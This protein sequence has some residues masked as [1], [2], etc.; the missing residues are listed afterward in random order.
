MSG[1]TFCSR[2]RIRSLTEKICIGRMSRLPKDKAKRGST[3]TRISSQLSALTMLWELRIAQVVGVTFPSGL[4]GRIYRRGWGLSIGFRKLVVH[5][6]SR[7]MSPNI[8]SKTP[9]SPS[10][11]RS[12]SAYVIRKIG[13]LSLSSGQIWLWYYVPRVIGRGRGNSQ[14]YFSPKHLLI[15]NWRAIT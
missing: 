3:L 4:H 2:M 13:L 12:G 15:T 1:Q 7:V 11:L 9:S 5:P 14:C 10:G 6:Q 8:C